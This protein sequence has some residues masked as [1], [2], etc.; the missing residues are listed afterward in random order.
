MNNGGT[1][2]AHGAIHFLLNSQDTSGGSCLLSLVD[3]GGA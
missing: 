2:P 1:L 3:Q